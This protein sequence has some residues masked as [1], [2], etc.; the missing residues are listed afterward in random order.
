VTRTC[1]D[2]DPIVFGHTC[3][4]G[5]PLQLA[6]GPHEHDW[7]GSDRCHYCRKAKPTEAEIAEAVAGL[8]RAMANAQSMPPRPQQPRW[9]LRHGR[10][11]HATT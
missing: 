9:W 5:R 11:T 8:E 6:A 7:G 3:E 2:A 4:Q 1:C 10:N